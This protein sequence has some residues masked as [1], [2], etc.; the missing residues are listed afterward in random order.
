MNKFK[1]FLTVFSKGGIVANPEAWKNGQITANIVIA[2]LMAVVS[3]TGVD[4]PDEVVNSVGVGLF[5]VANWL[6]TSA[7]STKVGLLPKRKPNH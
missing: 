1:A 7:T 2:V 6:F 5:A 3:L 4:I